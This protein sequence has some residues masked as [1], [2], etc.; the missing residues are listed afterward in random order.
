MML[1]G[2]SNGP[3][4][5]DWAWQ[6]WN[7]KY[8]LEA[9]WLVKDFVSLA[10]ALKALKGDEPVARAAWSLYLADNDPFYLGHSPAK[11]LSSLARWTVKA[12]KRTSVVKR[13]ESF[14]GAA[15]AAEMVRIL[16]EVEADASIPQPMKRDEAAKRWREIPN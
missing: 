12:A 15:R 3:A 2:D 1:H 13:S 9:P 8:G 16:R 11:F 5:K 7:D 10:S 6:E 14:P 4:F